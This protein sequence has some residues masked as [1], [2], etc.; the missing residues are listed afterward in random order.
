MKD[1]P[2][3]ILINHSASHTVIKD[4]L[5]YK[6]LSSAQLKGRPQ[7]LSKS[8]CLKVLENIATLFRGQ[9]TDRFIYQQLWHF[10]IFFTSSF[11]GMGHNSLTP[12]SSPQHF[13]HKPQKMMIFK[14]SRI[15]SARLQISSFEE[16][17]FDWAPKCL[18]SIHHTSAI[19]SPLHITGC[20]CLECK[21][22]PQQNSLREPKRIP[23]LW[24]SVKQRPFRHEVELARPSPRWFWRWY[25]VPVD[26]IIISYSPQSGHTLQKKR[27]NPSHQTGLQP[28]FANLHHWLR[29]NA[30]C[31]KVP[32]GQRRRRRR[33]VFSWGWNDRWLTEDSHTDR[34]R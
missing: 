8:A 27:E 12:W 16:R 21:R 5:T 17:V 3:N 24:D 26:A 9:I 33:C 6:F 29:L 34:C 2:T 22:I 20:S 13:P 25:Y 14:N 23:S 15:T 1:C 28:P 10:W 32:L 31:R 19:V 18:S 11:F 30:P 4:G 7:R